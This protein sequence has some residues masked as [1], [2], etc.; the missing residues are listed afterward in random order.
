M[1]NLTTSIDEQAAT[2]EALDATHSAGVARG[3]ELDEEIRTAQARI[4]ETRVELERATARIHGNHDRI[5][6][7]AAR[8]SSG[9]E[10]L[11]QLKQQIESL[12]A[13]R[14]NLRLFLETATADTEGA[15]QTA[16]AKQRE[17]NESQAQVNN[18]DRE[19]QQGRHQSMQL[20]Q[21]ISNVHREEAQAAESLA[22]LDREAQ[23]LVSESEQ[24]RHELEALGKQR[25][26][27]SLTFESV[28]DRLKRLEAE[29]AQLRLDLD[30]R[31]RE[32]MDTRRKGDHLRAEA[33]TLTG[34][35]NSLEALIRDHSYSSETVRKLFKSNGIAN[36]VAPAGTLADFLEVEDEYGA[37]VD[38]FLKEELNYIVVRNWSSADAGIRLL[39]TSVDGRATFLVH[40]DNAP[41]YTEG[42]ASTT[43]G[44]L[45]GARPLKDCIKVLNGFG[46]ALEVILPKLREGY[47]APD[48]E[49]ARTLAL[50]NPEA[51]SSHPPAKPSTTSPSP[52]ARRARRVHSPSSVS[53]VKSRPGSKPCRH[54]WPKAKPA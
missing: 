27:V 11:A 12:T 23:R 53:S 30:A 3:Y 41:A 50:E 48:T 15:R 10:E 9:T 7:L 14:D 26:Q 42:K 37:L 24:A 8:I 25:G 39:K 16:Q 22:G 13:D 28:T 33:A 45:R 35:R 46:R 38:E 5:S 44:D 6:D 4:N 49:T 2:L 52:A 34:R 43:H 31:R 36:S 51:S 29:I 32:E 20:M 1:T 19:A 17:A 40:Q 18:A 47:L 21:R 54:N